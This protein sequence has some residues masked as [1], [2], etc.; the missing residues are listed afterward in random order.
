MRLN[1]V[2]CPESL[3]TPITPESLS[4]PITQCQ[5]PCVIKSIISRLH[6]MISLQ[7]NSFV[8][9]PKVFWMLHLNDHLYSKPCVFLWVADFRGLTTGF[10]SLPTLSRAFTFGRIY[11]TK[12]NGAFTRGVS[13]PTCYY[14]TH[15]FIFMYTIVRP[16]W[17][18]P[19]NQ[20]PNT[21][22]IITMHSQPFHAM[23]IT[24]QAMTYFIL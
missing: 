11:I 2:P 6:S 13:I 3:P 10:A 14:P 20:T 7:Q 19:P 15:I 23:S 21:V 5:S 12:N 4:T 9:K 16:C 8:F 18:L 22:L 17:T 1:H 24:N